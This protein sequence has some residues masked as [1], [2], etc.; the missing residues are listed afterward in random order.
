MCL[1]QKKIN[2]CAYVLMCLCA[3]VLKKYASVQKN[4]LISKKNMCF[5]LKEK[6][7]CF[8]LKKIKRT[9]KKI[10]A[11]IGGMRNFD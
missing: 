10:W 7:M 8:Y 9:S 5:C 2:L 1:C 6:N 11:Y 3:Y 4:M